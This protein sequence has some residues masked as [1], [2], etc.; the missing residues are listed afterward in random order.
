MAGFP[1]GVMDIRI[2][3]WQPRFEAVYHFYST[4]HNHRIRLKIKLREQDMVMPSLT[5]LWPIA[6]WFEREA[7]DM[8]G[9]RYEGH[10]DLKR[11]LM[12]E[13]FVGFPLRKD[14]P[15]SKR[16]PLIGPRN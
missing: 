4:T 12:Y 13:E 11:I 16:Q 8:Y 2:T 15:Y 10:P 5:V 7:W 14:Y 9:V 6:N 3:G 1:L